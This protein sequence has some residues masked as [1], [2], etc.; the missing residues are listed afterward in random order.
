[1]QAT[2]TKTNVKNHPDGGTW[3]EIAFAYTRNRW[4]V[5][6]TERTTHRGATV[7]QIHRVSDKGQM[8]C[9]GTFNTEAEARTA[10][11]RLYFRD[12]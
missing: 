3:Q 10:A 1:M 12:K 7:F 5:A 11:N 9:L 4:G 8:L 6:V 2:A